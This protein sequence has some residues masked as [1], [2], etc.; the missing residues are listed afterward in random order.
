VRQGDPL[1]PLLFCLAE[2]VLSRSIS[3]LVTE[4]KLFQIKG[5]RNTHVPSHAFYAD[6]IMIYCKGNLSG[7]KALKELFTTY[8]L[9]SGQVISTSKST[10]F[11]GSITP[12]RLAL[13]VQ[14]LGFKVGSLPFNY[15][16]VPI[17]KGKPKACYLQP[18]ADKIKN[19]LS[20]WK[21]SLLSI[22]GRVQMVRSV[23]YSM[24]VYSISLY[25]WPVSLLKD[26]EKAI[27][28]FIWSGDVDQRKLVT[29]SW[30][31]VCR[32]FSQGGLNIRSL[33]N[34]NKASNL[35]L[36]WNLLNSQSSWAVL[37]RDRVLRNNSHIHYHIF[38]SIWSSVKDELAGIRDNSTWLIGNGNNINFWND[39][40][41]GNTLASHF[42]IPPNISSLLS[43]RVSDFVR[44]GTW[45]IPEALANIFPTLVTLVNEI[46]LPLEPDQDELLWKLTD[47]GRL[48]LKEAYKFK[49]HAWPT[50]SWASYIWSVDIPPAK[51][52]LVWRLML[53]KLPTD[54]NLR[55]RG[56]QIPSVCNLC[57]R[58]EETSSH[59]FFSCDFAVHLWSWLAGCL[60]TTLNLVTKDNIWTLCESGWS[61]QCKVTLNA[62]IINLINIIWFARNQIR[63]NNNLITATMAIGLIQAGTFLSGNNTRKVSSNS[64]KDLLFLKK[65]DINLHPP[66][67]PLVKE[68]IW[69]PPLPSW[70]KCNI[71]GASHG[72]PGASSCGGVFRDMHANFVFAFAE[73]LGHA[74]SYYAELCGAMRAI[75]IAYNN[76]WSHLWLESDSS[77]VVGAFGRHV[78]NIPWS[79]RTRWKNMK[80]ML[81]KVTC[82]VTHICREGNQVAD[83]LANHGLSLLG[84]YTWSDPPDLVKDFLLRNKNGLPNFRYCVS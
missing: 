27:R 35:L 22:A 20:S 45:C 77:L 67:P 44:N 73:P 29:V 6:D 53:D 75:E 32:P 36:G 1:S 12:G 15:L 83:A 25:S 14:H 51:S 74:N 10:I 62:A 78:N 18:I 65:F 47:D 48:T 66:R 84:F 59:L 81:R 16:G 55:Q 28:N 21:A 82:I 49:S 60:D 40:W 72:N 2:D 61:P 38:S 70:L 26:L 64:V 17:F 34:L 54:E 39:D 42:N 13:I 43:S 23:V 56:C 79:L 58:Y 46:P 63:Y 7:L 11:S 33:I 4:G 69:H 24:I 52:L 71:D 68:I 80:T 30:K 3:K 5:T 19:K 41:W 76:D 50:L 9:E 37:L 57:H 8:A 31:K